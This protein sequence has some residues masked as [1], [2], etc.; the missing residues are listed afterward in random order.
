MGASF[1][2]ASA[3]SLDMSWLSLPRFASRAVCVAVSRRERGGGCHIQYPLRA[4]VEVYRRGRGWAHRL[5]MRVQIVQA[6]VSIV[7][8]LLAVVVVVVVLL[9][10]SCLLGAARRALHCSYRVPSRAAASARRGVTAPTRMHG[11]AK[12][13]RELQNLLPMEQD[14]RR[15][16]DPL[17]RTDCPSPPAV[18]HSLNE[19]MQEKTSQSVLFLDSSRRSVRTAHFP[20]GRL[21]P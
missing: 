18:A 10:R 16:S 3:D 17:T 20:N 14:I 15:S 21:H 5:G 19:A 4:G 1:G 13:M 2:Y 8:L 6:E 11:S 12:P 7:P 9:L